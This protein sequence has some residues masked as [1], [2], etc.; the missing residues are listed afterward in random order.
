[1]DN[2]KNN[3]LPCV[4]VNPEGSVQMSV[5]WMHGLGA[6]GNDFVNIVPE[7]NLPNDLAIRFV[8]P[9]APMRPITINGGYVMRAW[10]DIKQLGVTNFQDDEAGIRDSAQAICKLIKHEKQLG[11]PSENIILAGFSQGGAIA[12][13]VGLRYPEKIAG[14]LAL[15]TYLP[16]VETV[17]SER[18]MTNGHV[19]IFMAHGIEDPLIPLNV[20]EMSREFLISNQYQVEWHAYSMQHSVCLEEI[21]DIG[22]WLKDKY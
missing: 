3:L 1:M 5:I 15:S 4:E 2:S 7:L 14:I 21:Q 20:A 11:V 18:E 17:M 12:L 16:L 13:H 10:Y 9:H 8:F 22:R 6:D 19:P